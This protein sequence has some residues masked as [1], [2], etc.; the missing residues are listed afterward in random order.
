MSHLPGPWK[1]IEGRYI[2]SPG[3]NLICELETLMENN[4]SLIASAPEMLSLIIDIHNNSKEY[5]HNIERL[6]D[7]IAKARGENNAG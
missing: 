4:A 5:E 3:G 7:I 6:G 1:V 2:Y